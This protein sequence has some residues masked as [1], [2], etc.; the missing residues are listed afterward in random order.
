MKTLKNY[1]II[2]K[3]LA[4]TILAY[5]ED[6]YINNDNIEDWHQIV[7]NTDYYIIGYFEAENWL[8]NVGLNAFE[9][10]EIVRDY[11]LENF[12]EFTTKVDSEKI[13]NMI[14]YIFGE[15]LL[16]SENFKNVK[17]LKRAMKEILPE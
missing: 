7:F 17:Q 14:A 8:K 13:V 2:K 6:K 10:I 15:E 11:E 9:A 1:P 16:Y 3:E 4:S 5:I 12:G